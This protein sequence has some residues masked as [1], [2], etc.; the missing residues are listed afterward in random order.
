M[1][2]VVE[3]REGLLC[4]QEDRGYKVHMV[5]RLEGVGVYRRSQLGRSMRRDR[6]GGWPP[7]SPCWR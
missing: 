4:T 7:C 3:R 5:E 6:I 1:E 2:G